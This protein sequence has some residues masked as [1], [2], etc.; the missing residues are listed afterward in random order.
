VP[1]MTPIGTL[2]QRLRTLSQ[3]R[4]IAN[5]TIDHAV[6]KAIAAASPDGSPMV[7]ARPETKALVASSTQTETSAKARLSPAVNNGLRLSSAEARRDGPKKSP[8]RRNN[9]STKKARIRPS[10]RADRRSARVKWPTAMRKPC[11]MTS[12]AAAQIATQKAAISATEPASILSAY[13]S[14]TPLPAAVRRE[15]H[16][17]MIGSGGSI[18]SEL[19]GKSEVGSPLPPPARPSPR[20]PASQHSALLGFVHRGKAN[21][22]GIA[23]LPAMPAPGRRAS[24]APRPGRAWSSDNGREQCARTSHRHCAAECGRRRGRRSV[25]RAAARSR[26]AVQRRRRA[27]AGIGGHNRLA[28]RASGRRVAVPLR[29]LVEEP[30]A[31]AQV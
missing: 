15:R 17:R 23:A 8:V 12:G 24:A 5:G 31:A 30:G 20:S 18:L 21:A 2:T 1:A 14:D 22:A 29:V 6:V 9:G 27:R 10:S 25:G 13:M 3:A 26:R 28:G 11:Q 7:S 4:E 19:T 16:T